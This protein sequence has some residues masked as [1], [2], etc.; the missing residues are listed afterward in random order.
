[1][2]IS[3]SDWDSANKYTAYYRGMCEG[4]PQMQADWIPVAGDN[5]T[6]TVLSDNDKTYKNF[7]ICEV[8]TVKEKAKC[9][10]AGKLSNVNTIHRVDNPRRTKDGLSWII[11]TPTLDKLMFR[12]RS[13]YMNSLS[14]AE[15]IKEIC[16][17]HSE[18]ALRLHRI[19]PL[20]LHLYGILAYQCTW[21]YEQK[22][23]VKMLSKAQWFKEL[24]SIMVAKGHYGIDV[25][26]TKVW[27]SGIWEQRY[28]YGMLARDLRRVIQ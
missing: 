16:Q 18:A 8:T 27:F 3:R 5:F 21:D 12:L 10:N 28:K 15:A 25:D 23:W 24:K 26:M 1:M 6:L 20:V 17:I 22:V 7:T 4:L 19:D 2:P 13:F 14:Q 9:F 11:F